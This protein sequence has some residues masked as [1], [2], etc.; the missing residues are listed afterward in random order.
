MT[1]PKPPQFNMPSFPHRL[2]GIDPAREGADVSLPRG[3][4]KFDNPMEHVFK[5]E[6]RPMRAGHAHLI[7]AGHY[8]KYVRD[9][10][11]KLTVSFRMPIT[12]GQFPAPGVAWIQALDEES[13]MRAYADIPPG[14]LEGA[15]EVVFYPGAEE[16]VDVVDEEP[17][18]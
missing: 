2:V 17:A 18:R 4:F 5:T 14:D 10:E 7:F 13:C 9:K 15:E 11:G 3:V 8:A 1:F 16:V 6:L 12:V